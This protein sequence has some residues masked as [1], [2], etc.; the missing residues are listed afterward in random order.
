MTEFMQDEAAAFEQELVEAA[1]DEHV[2]AID[3]GIA[4]FMRRRK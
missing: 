3:S 2:G 1:L 4:E